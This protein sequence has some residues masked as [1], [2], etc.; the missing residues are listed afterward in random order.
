METESCLELKTSDTYE[1]ELWPPLSSEPADWSWKEQGTRG[2]WLG[3]RNEL[4]VS[5]DRRGRR[6]LCLSSYKVLSFLIAF[7]ECLSTSSAVNDIF[8]P[9]QQLPQSLQY[10]GPFILPATRL[11]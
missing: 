3:I 4:W 6:M 7:L 11:N 9:I 1:S 5:M 10:A 2:G 8:L